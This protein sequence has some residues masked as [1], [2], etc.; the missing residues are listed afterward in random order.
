MWDWYRSNNLV[1]ILSHLFNRLKHH[2][3]KYKW[4]DKLK[5]KRNQMDRQI[6]SF[7]SLSF[8]FNDWLIAFLLYQLFTLH[9]KYIHH[10]F[11]SKIYIHTYYYFQLNK[12]I[13]NM[14][15]CCTS[16]ANSK[17]RVSYQ[18]LNISRNNTHTYRKMNSKIFFECICP[19]RS[20]SKF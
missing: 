11:I 16:A 18:T 19:I 4:K 14:K 20:E 7:F 17:Q 9:S 10:H 6:F 2:W 15:F 3:L 8:S 1:F 13:Q 12:K 5:E